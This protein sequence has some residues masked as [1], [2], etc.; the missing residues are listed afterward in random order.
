MCFSFLQK[1]F[2]IL[3][4]LKAFNGLLVSIFFFFN[5]MTA[6]DLYFKFIYIMGDTN[7]KF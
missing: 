7:F 6:G 5:N 2:C 4:F 3:S 1:Y